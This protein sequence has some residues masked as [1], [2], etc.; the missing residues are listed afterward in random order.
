MTRASLVLAALIACP[1]AGSQSHA[2]LVMQGLKWRELGPARGGR[3]VAVSGVP[4]RPKEFYMGT[5]GGGLWKSVDSGENWACVS[6]GFFEWG[7]VGAVGVAPSNPDVVY[8]GTGECDIRGNI[9]PGDGVYKSADGGKT[10]RH[11]GLRETRFVAKVRVHPT[12]PDTAYVAALGHVYGP[13]PERGVYKTTDG[14]ATWQKVLYVDDR[15]GGIDVE[16]DPADPSTLYAATWTA[17]RTPYE[18]NSGG[19]GSKLWKSTD[20]GQTWD[21]ISD[22]PG[23]PAGPLGKIGVA[24]SPADPKRVYAIV[25]ALDGGI[26]SSDDA[27]QTWQKVNAD[28][29]WRQRAWYYTHVVAHPKERDTVF[30]LN[31]AYG[32][33][34]DGGKTFRSSVAQHS[35]HHDLWIDPAEPERMVMGNDGG[36]CVTLDGGRAWTEQDYATAQ[37]YHVSAD[38]AFPYRLLGAQ[39][40]NS[41][42]RIPSRMPGAG[43]TE[44]DWTSTAG[45][46]SGYVSA[47]PDDPDIVFGGS[48]GGSLSWTNHRTNQRRS[49]DP[50]PDNPMGHGAADLGHR[51]QWTFPIVFSTHDPNVLYCTSQHVLRS[52][53]LGQNWQVVSPDLTRNDKSKMGPSGGPITKDNTSVE[54]YG[55]VFT[56]AESPRRKG[57]LWA[58]S[59]DGL[60]HVST[61]DGRTWQNV[62]PRGMPEWGLCSMVEPSPHDPAVAYLAVDNHENDDHAPYVFKT[63]DT[64]KTWTR[65]DA[66][67]PQDVFVRVVREDPTVR[68]LLYCGTE[69]SVHVSLDDGRTW[70]TLA[71]G[72]PKTPIHDLVVKDGDL[73]AA[74][75]GR[76]FWVLDNLGPIRQ[77]ASAPASGPWLVRPEN[78][79]RARFG[80]PVGGVGRNPM[81]GLVV[82]YVLPSAAQKVTFEILGMDGMVAIKD[83][84]QSTAAGHNRF[85]KWPTVP[86]YTVPQGMVFWTGGGRPVVMPPGRYTLRMTVDGKSFEQEFEWRMDPR[87]PASARDVQEQFRFAMVVAGR[88]KEA[89]DAVLRIR[90]HRKAVEAAVAA[91]P[92]LKARADAVLASLREVEEAIYQTRMQSG[93]DPLNYP[94]R[95]NDKLSGLFGFVVSGDG[96]PTSGAKDVFKLLDGQLREQLDRLKAVEHGELKA[97]LGGS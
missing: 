31:V 85:A 66:R 83:E 26:F 41:T 91:K 42:V 58:G 25:E 68:G 12:D 3:S 21:E 33:S 53:D 4:G 69:N 23:M 9:S 27:G 50:W 86:T 47:K 65:L 84:A 52:R 60:V 5:T 62:T 97:L 7:S 10:W 73:A 87:S 71:S 22:N 38:N 34:T 17:W 16:F 19:P 28:R 61:D 70:R 44:R 72:L 93:Q 88:V 75:H 20:A 35:D 81:S 45:G 2:D 64:G 89:N 95:L 15:S 36:A 92:D 8:V 37:F 96:A 6:D 51:F 79:V 24:P 57:L 1:L 29:N 48:Y 49:V 77:L 56:F 59:D 40:D 82:D 39:Q 80:A 94:I 76:S 90:E 11:V 78:A 43:V 14:G 63:A 74:T 30:V 67:L 55:T 13:N 46:E 54:Y 18:L 32:K